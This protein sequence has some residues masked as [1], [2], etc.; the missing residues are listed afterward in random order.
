[1]GKTG[2]F[3]PENFG[4]SNGECRK[5]KSNLE[6]TAD[7]GDW[8]LS[9]QIMGGSGQ[10]NAGDPSNTRFQAC[11]KQV[12]E[13]IGAPPE[14]VSAAAIMQPKP[15]TGQ[16]VVVGSI[17]PVTSVMVEAGKPLS[18]ACSRITSSSSAR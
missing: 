3:Y 10:P 7:L 6:V 5:F 18:L 12:R 11:L 17:M 9:A 1:M 4:I 2:R 15:S 14:S 16:L 13:R 8:L